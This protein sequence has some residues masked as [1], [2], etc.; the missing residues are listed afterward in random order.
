[1]R[2]QLTEQ[3]IG[4]HEQ[5]ME[6]RG[7]EGR[8]GEGRGGGSTGVIYMPQDRGKPHGT[9]SRLCL[10]ANGAVRA[11]HWNWLHTR[12]A[13]TT[14]EDLMSGVQGENTWSHSVVVQS[15][16]SKAHPPPACTGVDPH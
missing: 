8:G 2:K 14:W 9:G 6:G 7:G 4:T 15:D 10:A 3:E 11:T 16:T 12:T 5:L 13:H 1:M